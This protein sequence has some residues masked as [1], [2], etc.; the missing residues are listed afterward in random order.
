ML[1]VVFFGTPEIGAALL[2]HVLHRKVCEVVGVVSRPDK[3]QGRS[4]HPVSSPVK[5]VALRHGIPLLQPIRCHHPESLS[6][7]AE[8]NA[9]VFLVVAFGEI[10]RAEVL[11]VPRLGSW[12]VHAS[13]LPAYRGAAPMQWA[14]RHGDLTSGVSLQK[15]ALACDAGEVALEATVPIA[16][17]MNVADLQA[18]LIE[19]AKPLLDQFFELLEAGSLTLRPQDETQVTWA[20]KIELDDC[21]ID[22]QKP[23]EEVHNLV[24]SS[25]PEPG[26]FTWMVQN[27]TTKRLR[28]LRTQIARDIS[29]PAVLAPGA[30]HTLGSKLLVGTQTDALELL[31]VQP[32]GKKIMSGKDFFN[33]MRGALPEIL[34]SRGK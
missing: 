9:D 29:F 8:K 19:A 24:R 12:N 31:Q 11:N 6:W 23:A 28:V 1:K 16:E 22:W 5:E 32:E 33:G 34:L 7:L 10:L 3:P 17:A 30:L 25:S 2:E 20:P 18:A 4:K 27:G 21:Q 13:L 14:L 15:M 26:A